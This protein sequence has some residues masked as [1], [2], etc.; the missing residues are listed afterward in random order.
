MYNLMVVCF[1]VL[2]E[3]AQKYR[4][5]VGKAGRGTEVVLC[6]EEWKRESPAEYV[7]RVLGAIASCWKLRR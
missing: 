2:A 3:S 7:W 1:R 4:R 5:T 6:A